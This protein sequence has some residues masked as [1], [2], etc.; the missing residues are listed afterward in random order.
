MIDLQSSANSLYYRFKPMMPRW[1]QLALRR[2]YYTLKRPFCANSWPICEQC[3]VPPANWTGWPNGKRF[4]FVLTHDVETAKGQDRCHELMQLEEEMGFRS[5][6]NFVPLRYNVSPTLR[7]DLINKGF[8]VA[9]HDLY[10]DGK[11]YKNHDAFK[12]HAKAINQYLKEWGSVGF[13]SA[14]M[15]HNLDWLHYLNV[16]YDASTFDTDP[17]QPQ[18]DGIGTIFPFW[19]NS[20]G[21]NGGY[22]EMPYSLAQDHTLFIILRQRDIAVWKRKLQWVASKGG[23][24]LIIVHPDYMGFNKK[25]VGQDEYDADLYRQL[26]GHL[27]SEYEGQY[28]SALPRDV[29]RFVKGENPEI[30]QALSAGGLSCPKLK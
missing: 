14:S 10:H 5:S 3:G 9:V 29:A 4:A 11:L 13:R 8:E 15:L 30:T 26:L 24:A 16:E 27:K 22:V 28:W 2:S 25:K 19:V 6:F 12:G 17:F 23:M 20:K 21:S 18:T 7:K 1:L